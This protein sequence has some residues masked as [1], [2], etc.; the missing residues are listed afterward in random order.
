MS[1]TRPTPLMEGETQVFYVKSGDTAVLREDIAFFKDDKPIKQ[2]RTW[3]T[4]IQ[5]YNKWGENVGQ[6]PVNYEPLTLNDV[7]LVIERVRDDVS[8]TDWWVLLP[9]GSRAFLDVRYLVP[10]GHN[11]SPSKILNKTEN[12]DNGVQENRTPRMTETRR[13]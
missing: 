1:S 2:C 9:D 4:P 7:V 12:S 8:S 5:H 10:L 6:T 3:G 13:V 11:R